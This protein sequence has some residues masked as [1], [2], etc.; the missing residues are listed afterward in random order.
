MQSYG[1]SCD[2][3]A[4]CLVAY[5]CVPLHKPEMYMCAWI[6]MHPKL[7]PLYTDA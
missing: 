3:L 4:K 6:G 1:V 7:Y 5:T 2:R